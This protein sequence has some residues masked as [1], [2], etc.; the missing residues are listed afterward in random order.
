MDWL[1]L[2]PG[3]TGLG[4]VC[5]STA[6]AIA[7]LPAADAPAPAPTARSRR[8]WTVAR[9]VPV[10]AAALVACAFLSDVYVRTVRADT[11]ASS[12]QRLAD[13]RTAQRWNPL[14]SA[15][16]Y[17]QASALEELGRRDAARRELFGVL[18]LEPNS[19]VALGLLGDLET[20]AGNRREA[21]EWYR[22]ALYLNPQDTGLQQ[23]AR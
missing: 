3:L 5:L 16:R 20:R 4:I 14:A 8:A 12:A 23:L 10:V 17:L 6:V 1:W 2:I 19:F 21:R 15:P 9:A 11:R 7:A 22:R 18:A 13:A